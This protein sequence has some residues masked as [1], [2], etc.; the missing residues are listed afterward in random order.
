MKKLLRPFLS[1]VV[2]LIAIVA[3]G[4]KKDPVGNGGDNGDTDNPSGNKPV[5]AFTYRTHIYEDYMELDCTN[6][7]TGADSYVWTLDGPDSDDNQESTDKDVFFILDT[8]GEYVL[9]LTAKNQYGNDQTTQTISYN[10]DYVVADFS[11]TTANVEQGSNIY[12]RIQLI[13][14]SE[15]ATSYKWKFYYYNSHI[16]TFS[17]FDTSSERNPYIQ[18]Y[19][20]VYVKIELIASNNFST[21]TK[22][23]VIHPE[24]TEYVITRLKLNN[25]PATDGGSAWD[26]GFETPAAPDIF[27]VVKDG[28]NVIYKSPHHDNIASSD[29]PTQWDDLDIT[30]TYGKQYFVDFYDYDE[31][32]SDD[33]MASCILQMPES[34]VGQGYYLWSNS[35]INTSFELYIKWKYQ[36]IH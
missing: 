32:T 9:T 27:F 7:S 35:S 23:I 14:N 24:P 20:G 22:T 3:T 12:Y 31:L 1:I 5:A 4:C 25:I 18:F 11:Y 26:T 19:G 36:E 13:N 34:Y 15:N 6:T 28:E 17:G 2:T 21:D 30:L 8:E 16:G 33:I 29:L 10:P